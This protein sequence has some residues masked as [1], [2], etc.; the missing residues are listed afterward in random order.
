[1]RAALP[2]AECLSSIQG[3]RVAENVPGGLGSLRPQSPGSRDHH[4]QGLGKAQRS[5]GKLQEQG[6]RPH[7]HAGLLQG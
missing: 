3:E 6:H 2:R 1:M 7:P 4:R 5:V